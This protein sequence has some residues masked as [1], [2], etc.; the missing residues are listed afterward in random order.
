MN[1]LT[2]DILRQILSGSKLLCRYAAPAGHSAADATRSFSC[3]ISDSR[4]LTDAGA[5]I[6]AAIRTDVNDGRRYIRDMYLRGVR[7]FIVDELPDGNTF[8]DEAVFFVVSSVAEALR[9]IALFRLDNEDKDAKRVIVTGSYGK[10]TVKE[11]LYMSLLQLGV[12][13]RRSPRSWNSG[14]GIPLAIWDMTSDETPADVLILEAGIDGPGQAARMRPLLLGAEVG[15]ITAVTEEHNDNFASHSDKI[16]EKI[17]LVHHC[18]TIIYDNSDPGVGQL[19][20]ETIDPQ[21]QTLRPVNADSCGDGVQT[22]LHALVLEALSVLGH[23]FNAHEALGRVPQVSTRIDVDVATGNNI[24]VYDNFTADL[25]SLHD[26]LDFTRRRHTVTHTPLLILGDML[27]RPDIPTS[28]LTALYRRA[29]VTAR[30]FGIARVIA[31]GAEL[32]SLA[33]EL[34]PDSEF[35]DFITDADA[36]I[37]KYPA[38]NFHDNLILIKGQAPEFESIRNSLENASHDSTVEVDLDA[39]VHNYNYYRRCLPAGTRMV[40]MVKASAYGMGALEVAKTMQSQ[41]AAYLAVAVVDEG[42]ALRRAGVTMPVIILNPVTNRYR[43]LFAYNLEPTVFSTDELERL[44]AEA[45][46][47]GARDYPVHVKLDTGMHRVGFLESDIDALADIFKNQNRVTVASVFTHLATADCLDMDDYTRH[48]IELY[49][50]MADR[51]EER[52][53]RNFLRHYLNTAGITRFA[54][55]GRYDMVRL[56][57]GLYGVAPYGGEDERRNLRPVARLTSVIISLKHWPAGTPIGYGCRGVTTRDSVIAT[58][59]M[60]YADGINRHMGCGAAS[61]VVRGVE[62]PTIG[63]ICMDLCMVDVTDATGAAVGDRVEIFGPAMPVERQAKVL[64]T[65]PYEI[66]TSVSPRVKRLYF[67]R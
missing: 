16:R 65:I 58:V 29:L 61:F 10:T 31:V 57:V 11:L 39:L 17:E 46:L 60:G 34:D 51:F 37:E 6:F 66:L 7:A 45:G 50:R 55:S 27:H 67:H 48:Q 32:K 43:S 25:R 14:L 44:V 19:L 13:A 9:A 59:P 12:D 36:F 8:M 56:G 64:G 52:L 54:D 15:I 2:T 62:C 35:C 5:T 23:G 63:N 53:G 30:T 21:R 38:E 41:G 3:L 47:F 1:S 4:S 20:T 49:T 40:A 42:V 26:A 18:R 33:A 28:E 24:I 22:P